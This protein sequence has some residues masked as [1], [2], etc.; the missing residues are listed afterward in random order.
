MKSNVETATSWRPCGE[1]TVLGDI[2][3]D[4]TVH[5]GAGHSFEQ[6]GQDHYRFRGRAGL[7]PY[8]WRF[9][10]SIESPGDGREITLEVADFNHFGQELWQEAATV[11]SGDGEQW[12]DLGTESIRVVPWTPT[13]VPACDESID[14]GWHP[15]YGVQYRLRLDG[16][17]LWLASPAPYT[18]ERCR[19]RLR[20]LADRCEFF[21]VAELGP[22]HYSG[23]H[24]FPLQVV[25]VAK[26]GDDGSRLRV[27]VIAGEHPAE[28][29]G[30][31]AC[32]GLL[33][34]L[35][36][37]HDL[38][39]DFSFWVVPMVNVDGAVYGRTYHN[40]DPCDPG[41][42]GVNL[43]RD[44]GGH[45]QP[46]NQ[47]L[48]QLL[49]DVR[50]HCFLNLHNGRHRREFEVYS[51]P[52]PNLAVFMRHLRAHLPLPLQHWQPAQ[53]EG[54]GCREVR[55]AELAEMALCF[56][57]LVLRK[58]P[59]CTTFPESYR[60]VGMCVLRGIV[61]ALRDVYRRPHMKPAVPSTSTQSLR[62]RSSDFVAQLPPFYYVDDFAEFR[63]HIR[64]N[65]EVNGLPLEA[66]FFDVL[67][68]ATKDIETLTVSRDGCSPETLKMVDGWFR[69][70]SM[71][72]P[73]HKLSFEFDGEGEEIPFGD[74]LI[75]PE[76][77]PAADVL[78]GARDFRNYVRDTRVTEREHLRDWGPFRDRL[79]AGTFDV[80]D[81]EHMAEGL[82][83]WAASRQVLD[84]GHPYAGAV[85][86][87]EDKYD[88][89]DAA[90][91]TA[92]FAD[93]WARTGDETWRER[94]MM[95]RRYVCRNQVREPGN[96][97]R[98]GGFVHMVHGIWG[99]DFRRL[100]SPYPGIDG[101][102]TSVVIHL[103]CRA[104]DAGLP[105]TEPDRQVIRE[106]VQWI[107]SNEAM[108]GVFLH[109]EGARHD[110]QNMNALALSALVRGYSTLSEAGDSPPRAWLD[111][112]ERGIDHYLDGQEAIGVWPYIFGH[113]GARGQAYDS[114]NIP[115]H[116]IGL[117]HLTRVLD[118]APLA[119]HDR[120]RNA[121]RRAAR[122]YLCTA[123]LDG[124]TIDLDYDRRPELGND[125]CFAGFTWCRFT[126]AATLVRVARWCDDG[127]PWAELA[128]CLM[129]HVRRKRWRADDPS[130]APV[131]AHARPEAKLATWCQ[132]AEW[133]AVMLREMI[134]DLDAITSR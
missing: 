79:M 129:E 115:D 102:D 13:G 87:E 38:L 88:A 110:C 121:L 99:V 130:K 28:S 92:A 7:A 67:L 55:K 52:H 62:L 23:D 57:T 42:P 85:Y 90:A 113:T 50:P 84:S 101:V 76:G 56:E 37:T 41:S 66:G 11:V 18:L 125:I 117:Y 20:A 53:S 27:V 98:H 45:T 49:Q 35:L 100:T 61:G 86:S 132:T 22:S 127:G 44:W 25:K 24:G 126:A 83:Q 32:E 112:A 6:I 111:A 107:A 54:M 39:A 65:L 34:E 75:A 31:Y 1:R 95:A 58:V 93:A 5:C 134:E 78:A 33:E 14:D 109:H 19:R 108:P 21:T 43:N 91:A 128:L 46:E 4:S 104:V 123:R 122:W 36:R 70:R 124:D 8:S 29:A 48:W 15:P 59:G 116:G 47:V 71:H 106:A 80:P 119:G 3:F 105:F 60:R 12:T 131:V 77:M 120:L 10:L 68:E 96:L 16:P 103:L 17:R 51:L 64:R 72:V 30:M 63:D 94:A 114:A 74:V 82:V 26:P 81:L 73:A 69:L 2:V 97:P 9:H 133:D 89:R 118:R 40:V